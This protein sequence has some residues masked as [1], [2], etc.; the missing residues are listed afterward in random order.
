MK[1]QTTIIVAL[2]AT[3]VALVHAGAFDNA[4]VTHSLNDV[5]IASA[6][7]A[8]HPAA[9]PEIIDASSTVL[10]GLGSRTEFVFPDQT[11]ARLGAQTKLRFKPGS[12][13][14][15]LDCGTLMLQTPAFHGGARVHTGSLTATVGRATFLI[16]HLPT[17]SVKIVVLEG[18]LRLS[19][20]GFLG[21]SIVLTPGKLLITNPGVRRIPDPVDVDLRVLTKTSSLINSDLFGDAAVSPVPTLPSLPLIHRR[22]S[23][24][25]KLVQGR[26][27]IPTNLVILGSGTNIVIP[28][29]SPTVPATA[30]SS[31]LVPAANAPA[32]SACVNPGNEEIRTEAQS[33]C[34][35][36]PSGAPDYYKLTL[37]P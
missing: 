33:R 3:R 24:Q 7:G 18:E 31:P 26:T 15:L 30:T 2:L 5:R 10:T 34:V 28:A 6:S 19:A 27:L 12:R 9:P 35:P 4:E 32:A 37:Q 25:D 23:R 22:I 17:K 16:E 1:L 29:A 36:A 14:L 8:S 11:L 20:D 13:D 21:D